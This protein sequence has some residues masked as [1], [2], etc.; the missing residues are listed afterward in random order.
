[1]WPSG[2]AQVFPPGRGAGI[3][4]SRG[5]PAEKAFR[6]GKVGQDGLHG[7]FQADENR[8]PFLRGHADDMPCVGSDRIG[9]AA[10]RIG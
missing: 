7:A 6:G 1:M 3:D 8:G 4:T 9:I 10:S 5:R 2:A